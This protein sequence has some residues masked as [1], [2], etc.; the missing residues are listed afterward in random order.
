MA[1]MT[2]EF[3]PTFSSER[4]RAAALTVYILY[5]LSIPSA[6]VFALI[7]VI[8]AYV[9]R[10]DSGLVARAHLDGAIALWWVAFLWGVA[11]FVVWM[12][13]LI[14]TPVLIGFPILALQW[15]AA[16]VVVIWFIVKSVLGLVALMDNRA[17]G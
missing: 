8:V 17:P 4:G 3:R 7:G 15:A 16:I 13:G 6:G 11:L 12:L 2:D 5:L 1:H 14:L 10:A 9:S